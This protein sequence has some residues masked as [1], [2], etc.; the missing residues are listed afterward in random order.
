MSPRASKLKTALLAPWRYFKKLCFAIGLIVLIAMAGATVYVVTFLR[1]LPD[2]D[3]LDYGALQSLAR[4]SVARRLE[5]KRKMPVWVPIQEVSRDYLYTIV[6]SEDSTFFEHEGVNVDAILNSLA[7]NIRKRKVESGASTISQQIVKNLFLNDERKLSRKVKELL[8]TERIEK[9]FNKNQ[10]LEI[11]LNMAEFGPDLFGIRAAADT[12]FH[13]PP[14]KINAAEG[15]FIALMLPSPRKFYYAVFQNRYLSLKKKR[16]VRRVLG[17]MLANELIS[18]KQ[19]S[20]YVR[21]KYFRQ[22]A[23]PNAA[24]GDED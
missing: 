17:D 14:S 1:S 15:A 24:A 9:R 13:K 23:V 11:Y 7:E 19:Y 3:K 8:I 4:K 22:P 10:L 6:M 5:D 21:Y 18:P 2:V 12:Y 20:Q 16:K